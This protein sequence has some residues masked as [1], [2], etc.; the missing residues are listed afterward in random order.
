[1]LVRLFLISSLVFGLAAC[2]APANKS[3]PVPVPKQQVPVK[4]AGKTLDVFKSI[5][6]IRQCDEHRISLE[7]RQ[8]E[9]SA[10]QVQVL[11]SSCG[12]TGR[13]NATVCGAGTSSI[14]IFTIPAEDWAKAEAA[15]F[16]RLSELPEARQFPCN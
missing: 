12:S 2:Q 1:M 11:N 9:L 14:G 8:A 4:P 7:D 10:A 16:K 13:M 15:Q 3:E 6:P 5:G